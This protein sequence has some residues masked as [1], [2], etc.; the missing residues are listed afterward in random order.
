MKNAQHDE[1]Q[2]NILDNEKHKAKDD[3]YQQKIDKQEAHFE[4]KQHI[5]LNALKAQ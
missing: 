1:K 3:R 4:N 2:K 5:D